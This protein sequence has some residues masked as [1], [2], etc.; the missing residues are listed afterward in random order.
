MH[1][2][3]ISLYTAG[4]SHNFDYT[5]PNELAWRMQCKESQG[6]KVFNCA[7]LRSDK[8][9][10]FSNSL[11]KA[12]K[13]SSVFPMVNEIHPSTGLVTFQIFL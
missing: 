2:A 9:A 5:W 7:E 1:F 3:S 12:L 10:G 6:H 13:N 4:N 11:L 8:S